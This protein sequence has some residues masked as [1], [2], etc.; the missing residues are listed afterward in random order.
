MEPR[1]DQRRWRPN[2]MWRVPFHVGN[3]LPRAGLIVVP[4][5]WSGVIASRAFSRATSLATAVHLQVKSGGGAVCQ[6]RSLRYDRQLR[7][8]LGLATGAAVLFS[9]PD[10]VVNC[11]PKRKAPVAPAPRKKKAGPALHVER[12]FSAAGKMHHDLKGAMED[13]SLEH[14]LIARANS[15]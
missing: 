11:A 6:A 1:A 12:L 15:E 13:G 5:L 14:S 10:L 3:L 8:A 2:P 7:V 4:G 9:Q